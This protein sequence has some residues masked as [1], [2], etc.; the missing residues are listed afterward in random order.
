MQMGMQQA[1]AAGIAQ[2]QQM[3]GG[4][5]SPTEHSMR[6]KQDLCGCEP[7]GDCCFSLWCLPC[8]HAS[9]REYHDGSSCWLNTL[10][11]PPWYTL[12]TMKVNYGIGSRQDCAEDLFTGLFCGP[13]VARRALVEAKEFPV[14]RTGN[15]APISTNPAKGQ[16]F[17]DGYYLGAAGV[18]KYE[19]GSR[20][21]LMWL[22][23]S[24][25]D[26]F[27]D[28]CCYAMMCPLC[29][30]ARQRTMLDGSDCC[31]NVCTVTPPAVYHHVRHY[32]GIDGEPF[33]DFFIGIFCYPFAIDRLR[34]EIVLRTVKD[35]AVACCDKCCGSCCPSCCVTGPRR[36]TMGGGDKVSPGQTRQPQKKQKGCCC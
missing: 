34:R 23:G 22:G 17:K 27:P 12:N 9:A 8:A 26:C 13:C 20:K 7:C 31:L 6:W 3:F 21:E 36:L 35:L 25:S 10:T 28:Y 15:K 5:M 16:I 4:T 11:T 18:G 1:P 2:P 24:L 14:V 19:P 33:T 30:S 32:Y 29:A